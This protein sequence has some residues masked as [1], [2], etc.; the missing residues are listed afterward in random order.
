MKQRDYI[1]LP[2]D[3]L[4]EELEVDS[5]DFEDFKHEVQ[6]H[7]RQGTL[8]K[9]KKNRLCLPR[10]ADLVTGRLRFRQ[11]GTALL[12]PE[13]G[14]PTAG[15]QEPILIRAEDTAVAMH[16]DRV[17]ARMNQNPY[18]RR[19]DKGKA[20]SS[21]AKR[22][23]ARKDEPTAR[24]IRILERSNETLTGTLRRSRVS[25]FVIPGDPRI[26]QDIIVPDPRESKVRPKPQPNDKVVVRLAP[27]EQRHL[28]PEGEI[29]EVL[30]TTH[31][32]G[33][34]YKALLH[35][36][37]LDPDFPAPVLEEV[38]EI[39]EKVPA[40]ALK[41]R[42]DLRKVFTFTIDP[43]DAKDFDDALS[44][45]LLENGNYRIGV[46]IADVSSYVRPG[47]E[48]DREAHE[49]GNSTYLVGKVI[50]MLPHELSNGICSL[51]ED[52]DRLTKSVFLEFTPR[53]RLLKTEFANTVIRSDK[54][55]TYEQAYMLLKEDD[56]EQARAMPLPPKHQTGST[57]RAL[58]SLSDKELKRLQS[59]IRRLWAV[60]S[61]LRTKRMK[62]SSLELDMP[63][64]KIYVDAEGWADQIVKIEYD[65]SHQ[66][67]EEF[68]LAANESVADALNKRRVP[69]I[70]RVHDKPDPNKLEELSAYMKSAGI[71]CG[72]LT[73]K[74]H[75]TQLLR[76]IREHSQSH[77][78]RVMVLRS[79]KQAQYRAS[80]DGHYGL[81]KTHYLHFTSP[82]RRY[83]D[84]VVHRIFD[85]YLV[86]T[87][88]MPA[89]G[90]LATY[91]ARSLGQIAQHISITE[92]NSTDAERESVKLKLLEF[93]ERELGKEPKTRFPA[94]IMDIRNHG[95][96]VELTESM[97]Y[98]L[99]HISTL[100]DDL[101]N[102]AEDGS[103]LV[104]RRT[105]R[106]FHLGETIEVSVARVD[107]FKRQ[108][109]FAV[110]TEGKPK[111]A[112]RGK[113]RDDESSKAPPPKEEGGGKKRSRSRGRRGE[114][115]ERD[116]AKPDGSRARSKSERRSKGES[117]A[118][119]ESVERSEDKPSGS[120]RKANAK[121]PRERSERRNE[122][123]TK[124]SRKQAK[125]QPVSETTESESKGRPSRREAKANPPG[126]RS[127]QRAEGET[128]SSRRNSKA[129][130]PGER[131]GKGEGENA[132]RAKSQAAAP[133]ET[134]EPPATEITRKIR[135]GRTSPRGTRS[136]RNRGRP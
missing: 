68:M 78:L 3:R 32:P 26:I 53:G 113:G 87:E 27:W 58:S 2:V 25:W 33:A 77:S 39:P 114:R 99:V 73:N 128:S 46:H 71:E 20:E 93:F 108:I 67:I 122:G 41:G 60:G 97:A 89:D 100:E 133:R 64:T 28:N 12:L 116:G 80:P 86:P 49:R 132:E 14:D 95:M 10:D 110:A 88:N 30:G 54:R 47:T 66:L 70:H 118:K 11:S 29:I 15:R 36:Y 40:K 21:G 45:E 74:K 8:V 7:L 124:A 55:L 13:S 123:E 38:R 22:G 35:Q 121:P 37:K 104:G 111:K 81:G 56:V 69:A 90:E 130:P 115:T 5:D 48:L 106:T 43:Q 23:G 42:V 61:I 76:D 92:Q 125:A 6:Q 102:P 82:I 24:V 109:D 107:R 1:P 9:L 79:L 17:V 117:Q 44:A 103:K 50:P 65:E 4:A 131:T 18:Q 85:R 52:E 75:M 19:K 112:A 135:S 31:T 84:L 119:A 83:A 120:G 105:K 51:V 94:V 129:K 126:K 127:A 91:D 72:D 63:E 62:A 96:F 134:D 16:G 57:G 98:G 34:E 101:Y 59:E 136:R